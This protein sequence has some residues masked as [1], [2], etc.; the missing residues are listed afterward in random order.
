M[1]TPEF[2]LRSEHDADRA[3]RTITDVGRTSTHSQRPAPTEAV[4]AIVQ[5]LIERI[6]ADRFDLWFSE[7]DCIHWMPTSTT[8]A[9]RIGVTAESKFSLNRI[10]TTFGRDLRLIVDRVCGPHAEL[11]FSVEP[12][13]SVVVAT[14]DPIDRAV[15][16]KLS[17]LSE[18]GSASDFN[19]IVNADSNSNSDSTNTIPFRSSPTGT[20]QHSESVRNRRNLKS[21][22]FGDENR[23]AAASVE[24]LMIE[25][26]QFSPFYV[27]GPTGSGKTHLLEAV[28][29]EFRSRL[30][31]RRCVMLSAEQFTSLFLSSLRGGTGLPMFRRKYRDL[32]LLVIDDIQFFAGKRATIGEFQHTIDNLFRLGKQVIVSSDRPPIELS[33]LGGDLGTRLT[34]GLSCPLKYPGF[35]SRVKIARRFCSERNINLSLPVLELVCERLTRDV[36]RIS[37]A[38]NRL[39]ALMLSTGDAITT[40]TALQELGD[41][42]SMSSGN[43][44]S[45]LNIET[46]V[47]DFCGVK[48]ADLKSSSRHK[49][50]SSARMLAMYLSRQYTSAAFSEIGDY[51]GGRSHST[52]IAA[53]KKVNAWIEANEGVVLPHATCQAKDVISRLESNLRI[54]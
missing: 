19:A 28:V 39:H 43:S 16:T 24:Q 8:D 12:N 44:T 52:V 13:A 10:Q 53:Q 37:G 25:P 6:G 41:L 46:A 29:H 20:N 42:F 38:I 4:T 3:D 21:F 33:T 2:Q 27:Y 17:F 31:L 11:K 49:Q 9:P 47:C 14:A 1:S 22:S 51:F 35:D 40:E 30:R 34:A 50:I 23:L 7:A 15:Q 5:L 26:G 45:L 32:D 18:E 54:G 36:R 48:P